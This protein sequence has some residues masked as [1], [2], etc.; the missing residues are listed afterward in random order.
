MKRKITNL[1]R[2]LLAVVTVM[3]AAG[4]WGGELTA[5]T[6]NGELCYACATSGL[7]YGVT[8]STKFGTTDSEKGW[9]FNGTYGPETRYA[10]ITPS[11]GA[12]AAGDIIE[13]DIYLT[14][15]ETSPVALYASTS[16]TTAL[17]TLSL[18]AGA[19]TTEMTTF[20]YTLVADDGVVGKTSITIGRAG[21]GATGGEFYLKTIRVK[22]TG[23][24]DL[25]PNTLTATRTWDFTSSTKTDAKC[26]IDDLFYGGEVTVES[27]DPIGLNF[28]NSYKTGSG[29]YTVDNAIR[30]VMFVVPAGK[31]I[32]DVVFS[33]SSE[34]ERKLFQKTGSGDITEV[35]SV[36]TVTDGVKFS[37]PY[38][39]TNET[40]IWLAASGSNV[41]ARVRIKSITVKMEETASIGTYGFA[42]FSSQQALDFS[43]VTAATPYIANNVA[44]GKVSLQS[45]SGV[46]P[47]N[48][49][50]VLKRV[51]GTGDVTIPFASEDGESVSNLLVAVSSTQEI[52]KATTG[53]NYVLSVQSGNVV[54]API[55]G[56]AA[57][58]KNGQAYLYY[59]AGS[60]SRPLT[61]SFG[62]DET[63]GVQRIVNR[64]SDS[65][66]YYNLQGQRVAQPTKGLYVVNGKKVIIK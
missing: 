35:G 20:T 16:E 29:Y 23:A 36:S 7:N 24:D 31:G 63:T 62:D 21:N 54:F 38:T 25:R 51:S 22:R 13:L 19:S 11:A 47:A 52:S 64:E 48:T 10:T 39:V 50:L 61:F 1:K 27:S 28:G 41:G 17:Q 32:V 49:G 8:L 59:S 44:D 2:M 9:S 4:A 15:A 12:F 53:V 66:S 58:V 65:E 34:A 37:F 45:V 30:N 14:N 6:P 40:Q 56:S 5:R 18:P 33:N 57:T 26:V 60:L 43:S 55:D 3:S 42:T 46:V